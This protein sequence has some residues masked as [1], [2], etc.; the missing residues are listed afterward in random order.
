MSEGAASEAT[1]MLKT[2]AVANEM[3]AEGELSA[4]RGDDLGRFYYC[5]S[6]VP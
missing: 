6:K 3:R 4:A 1:Q 5:M 2:F